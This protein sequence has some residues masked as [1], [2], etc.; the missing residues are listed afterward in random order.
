MGIG[1]AMVTAY[2]CGLAQA[3]S[4]GAGAGSSASSSSS[5]SAGPKSSAGKS[6]PKRQTARTPTGQVR[7]AQARQV[8]ESHVV[9]TDYASNSSKPPAPV[10]TPSLLNLAAVTRR[11]SAKTAAAPP[12]VDATFTGEPSIVAQVVTA[13]LRLLK[14]IVDLVGGN[15]AG[16]GLSVP[17]ITDGIPPFFVTGGLDVKNEE[18]DGWNV[19]TLT[20]P[21][22]TGEVVI[23][24][25]GGSFTLQ[26]SIFHWITYANLAR[27]TG[28]T[29]IVPLYPLANTAGTGGT[30][31]TVVPVMADF[32]AGQVA[33]HGAENVSVLGDSAGGTIGMAAAQVLISRC[34]GDQECLDDSLP[35]RLVLL[36]P[37]LDLS[38]TNPYV[39]LIDDPLLDL[40]GGNVDRTIWTKGLE[41]PDDPDG[42]LNPLA[43]PLFGSLA[44]LPITTVYAGSMDRTA[45]SV[46]ALQQKVA[47]MPGTHFTFELRK[48]E[49]HDWMIFPL[50]DA[51]AELP[52]MYD[53]LGV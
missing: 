24:I 5:H 39:G 53:A 7:T 1:A 34:A 4:E 25:H 38:S 13:G 6:T 8:S 3:D 23:G 40:V 49:F 32:I 33:A 37:A 43:S 17:F 48:G 41:T 44:G 14:P 22:P 28:A 20:P 47:D 31:L 16:S 12:A 30:A 42:T 29:V 9:P 46:L 21:E 10:E 19:W 35:S 11:I 2:G 45:A 26:A 50:P 15:I 18:Y 36:S 51:A 52:G 27:T